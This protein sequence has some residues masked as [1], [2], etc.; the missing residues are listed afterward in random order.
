MHALI[1]WAG[2]RDNSGPRVGGDLRIRL[3]DATADAHRQLDRS[4]MAFDLKT[5]AGYRRFLEAS[6]G[7]LLPLEA[8]LMES[9]VDDI[10]ED[11]PNRS[12]TDAILEDLAQ[13][14]G[15]LCLMPVP[16]AFSR[17]AL[18]GT[19]Y[20]LEGSRLGARFLLK[21]VMRSADPAVAHA[22]AYLSHGAGQPLWETYLALLA[23]E[24]P[25]LDEDEVIAGAHA[26]FGLF[27]IAAAST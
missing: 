1:D 17:S 11:W 25:R 24:A 23:E 13:P 6:A 20:V 5:V 21:I 26:A 22:T 2:S 27:S 8:A 18:L 4:L 16:A 3:K 10:V 15:K 9:G 19:I 7:A 14:D 12:R